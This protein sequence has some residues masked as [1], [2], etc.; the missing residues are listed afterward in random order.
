VASGAL[1]DVVSGG[2]LLV[3]GAGWPSGPGRE[4]FGTDLRDGPSPAIKSHLDPRLDLHTSTYTP[5]LQEVLPISERPH[6][7]S[8]YSLLQ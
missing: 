7:Y 2:A 5:H 6:C 8:E 4:G 1:I 3:F